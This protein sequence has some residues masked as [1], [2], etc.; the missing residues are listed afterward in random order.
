ML[1]GSASKEARRAQHVPT[2]LNL[3]RLLHSNERKWQTANFG[4]PHEGCATETQDDAT[5]TV[6]SNSMTTPPCTPR[7]GH[8]SGFEV[9][10]DKILV[11]FKLF[12]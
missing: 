1:I 8:A 3:L 4:A 2:P 9:H 10:F 5:S 12:Q 6:M 7:Q 11:F